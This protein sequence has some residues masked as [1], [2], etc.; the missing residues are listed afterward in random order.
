MFFHDEGAMKTFELQAL[1]GLSNQS[2]QRPVLFA[3][4]A[5]L[6]SSQTSEVL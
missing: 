4:I 3:L 5:I 6:D 1:I 2:V